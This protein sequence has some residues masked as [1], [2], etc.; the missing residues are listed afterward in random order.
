MW[1]REENQRS[2]GEEKGE[3]QRWCKC[4]MGAM[5]KQEKTTGKDSIF[6]CRSYWESMDEPWW[7]AGEGN[8]DESW[9]KVAVEELPWLRSTNEKLLLTSKNW[10]LIPPRD[11]RWNLLWKSVFQL[12]LP[13][14]N[15]KH[16]SEWWC[17][18]YRGRISVSDLEEM[19]EC[20]PIECA[21]DTKSG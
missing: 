10:V 3:K 14:Q 6:P 20:S 1:E 13:S 4:F 11:V 9:G 21:G 12:A 15:C 7:E 19:M 16:W 2:Q 8:K 17:L 5:C 18:S